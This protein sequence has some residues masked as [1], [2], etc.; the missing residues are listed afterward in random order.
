MAIIQCRSTRNLSIV[1]SCDVIRPYFFEENHQAI[2]ELQ[3]MRQRVKNVCFRQ[4]S[5]MVYV[6]RQ[7]RTFHTGMSPGHSFPQFG[8]IPWPSHCPDLTASEFFLWGYL[9]SKVYATHLQPT[10]ELKD[11]IM[12][13]NAKISG[14]LL[15]QVMRTSESDYDNISN[16]TEAIWEFVRHG[17]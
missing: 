6:A 17:Y 4:D 11:H 12:E 1:K 9:R 8:D 16:V 3:R 14:A 5:A 7:S 2:M 10:K 15:Q 13:G